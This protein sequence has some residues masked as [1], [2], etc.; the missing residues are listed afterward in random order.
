M[1]I[2]YEERGGRKYAYRCTSKRVPGKKTPVSVKEYLGAVDPATGEIVPKKVEVGSGRIRAGNGILRS[3]DYG[4]VLILK[5]SCDDIRIQD[6]LEA[7]F[8]PKGRDILA[9]A[10][11]LAAEPLHFMDVHI[12]MGLGCFR[13]IL[14]LDGKDF[15]QTFV[16]SLIRDIG[17]SEEEIDRFFALR[18][19]RAGGEGYVINMTDQAIYNDVDRLYEWS[20][21]RNRLSICV[22]TDSRGSPVSFDIIPGDL[23]EP[24]SMDRLA[25]GLMRAMDEMTFTDDAAFG[26]PDALAELMER[27]VDLVVSLPF[28]QES[29]HKEIRRLLTGFHPDGERT[30]WGH[31]FLVQKRTIGI[32]ERPDGSRE[33]V[34]DDS[35][36]FGDSKWRLNAYITKDVERMEA[37]CDVLL[38]SLIDKIKELDGRV[39]NNPAATFTKRTGQ[40]GRYL[41]WTLD[42]GGRMNLNIKPNAFS[43]FSNRAGM[44]IL[45]SSSSCWERSMFPYDVRRNLGV[46]FTISDTDLNGARAMADPDFARGRLFLKMVSSMIRSRTNAVIADSG[47]PDQSL[48]NVLLDARGLKIIDDGETAFTSRSDE[49]ARRALMLFGIDPDSPPKLPR[50]VFV[51]QF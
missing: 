43:F 15:S 17:S 37:E 10:M 41:Q 35:A 45:L 44:F 13:E 5:R 30:A 23:R 51:A 33:F 36:E 22:S 32:L 28:P 26:D 18:S 9:V 39:F 3:R 48:Y 21:S 24:E 49:G 20:R 7:A 38:S 1:K 4:N 50:G 11:T 6:D 14:D 16:K 8:G 19:E 47:E 12:Q 31:D 40:A 2:C 29:R 34:S 27:G 25:N 42:E 46:S